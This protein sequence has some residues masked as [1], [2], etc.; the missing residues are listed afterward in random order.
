[1][2]KI[3]Q[4]LSPILSPQLSQIE[5]TIKSKIKHYGYP[6]VQ[7]GKHKNSYLIMKNQIISKTFSEY[8]GFQR[9]SNKF[10]YFPLNISNTSVVRVIGIFGYEIGEDRAK[11]SV[12]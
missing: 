11:K 9:I 6:L 3:S 12:V 8:N 1:M 2:P 4:T 7:F 5:T 10:D